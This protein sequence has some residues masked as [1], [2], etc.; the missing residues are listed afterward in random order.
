M[1]SREQRRLTAPAILASALALAACAQEPPTAA[2]HAARSSIALA[3]ENGAQALAPQQLAQAT[4]KLGRAQAAVKNSDMKSAEWL[5]EE[6]QVDAEL[7][8]MSSNAQRIGN[9]ASELQGLE[10]RTR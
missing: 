5:A 7:A 8:G 2:I 10:K 6:S 1:T 3:Q 9:T 4:D